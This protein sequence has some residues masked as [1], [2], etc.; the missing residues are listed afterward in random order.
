MTIANV[1]GR[2]PLDFQWAIALLFPLTKEMNDR[3]YAVLIIKSATSE[4]LVAAKFMVKI[5][6]NLAC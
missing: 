3:V 4:N 6:T 5:G 2:T 1:L